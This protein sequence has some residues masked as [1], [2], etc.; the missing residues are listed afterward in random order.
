MAVVHELTPRQ[1]RRIALRAQL[2]DAERPTDALD[3]V[4][5]LG[6]LQVDLTRVVAEHAHLAL[7]TRLGS[8]YDAEDLEELIGDGALVEIRGV[9]RPSEDVALFAGDMAAWPGEPPLKEWQEDLRDW[10]AANDGCR[11][12]VLALLRAEGP[13][14]ARDIP[15]TCEVPW[16]ST[17]W[18]NDKNVMKLLECMEARGEVAV[19]SREGRERRWDLAERIHPGDPPVP[20]AEAH[21]E[22]AR[23]R[24]RAAGI[25]RPRA[26]ED[27]EEKH[28]VRGV[29]EGARIEGVRGAWR[30][31]PAYLDDYF[32]GRTAILSPLD[33][34]VFDRKRMEDVFGFD[35]QLEM[36]KPAAKR[37]WGYWAMPV[38]DG[39]ELVGKVDATAD[40]EGG[41][42]IV[43]A[44][45]E[46][47]EWSAARRRR[48]D[49]ELAALGE[50]LGLEVVRS[51]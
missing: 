19:A 12:D 37:Q 11:R 10:V 7:W 49:A 1:A 6:F 36:Y 34:L 21:L 20:I 40:R 38:L 23:R 28:D 51:S 47:G 46:D 9:L 33:R 24:L 16:R 14:A 26:L 22:L 18:T 4:R 27:Y 30:V 32:E 15:D 8:R 43:D 41:M 48:V 31:D 50:W 17:G 13:T 45:H 44:V 3:V 25:A 2:L 39:D 42:L 5:H 35:Y 29:G